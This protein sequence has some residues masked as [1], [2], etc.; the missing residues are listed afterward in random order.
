[1][2]WI[3]ERKEK[4]T[5]YVPIAMGDL[6]TSDDTDP[7]AQREPLELEPFRDDDDEDEGVHSSPQ[8]SQPPPPPPPPP[9][10]RAS[11]IFWIAVNVTAT[12]LIVLVNKKVLSNPTL[13]GAP[14]LFVAYHFMLTSI[15]L[16]LSAWSGAFE[17]K[18]A[19][20]MALMPLA[21]VF[22]AHTV[23]TNW[24]LALLEVVMYQEMRILITPVTVLINFVAYR[25]TISLPS[26]GALVV[27]CLGVALTVYTDT[28]QKHAIAAAAAASHPASP[29]S[30]L[31]RRAID[32]ASNPK[33]G[34]IGYIFGMG[35][36]MLSALYTIWMAVYMKKLSLSAMQ[37]LHNQAPL[38]CALLLATVPFLDSLPVWSE[39]TLYEWMLLAVSG[40]CAVMIN[41]SQFYIVAGSSALSSTVV[42]H[43]K[44]MAIVAAGWITATSVISFGSG[45]GVLIAL[46]GIVSYGA[47]GLREA[48]AKK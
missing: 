13:R 14:I 18:V 15:T 19:P 41:V 16:Q 48:G 12:L 4:P 17:A 8:P 23:V 20:L 6:T 9:V 39:V 24:S 44:T 42:G 31:L 1:M 5:D 7:A 32:V 26:L 30:H 38:G 46:S 28:K 47:I 21:I 45:L 22:A 34:I 35:G 25:K 27:V 43:G 10:S 3:N 11:F 29:A 33:N 40:L 2:S 36:V 37:L